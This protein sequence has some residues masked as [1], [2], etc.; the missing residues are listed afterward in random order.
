MTRQAATGIRPD[1]QFRF[2][3]IHLDIGI[4]TRKGLART[5]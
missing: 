4:A 3:G 1:G 2:R 5:G